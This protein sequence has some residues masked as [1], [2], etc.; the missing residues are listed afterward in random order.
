MY[1]WTKIHRIEEGSSV[2]INS[3][4]SLSRFPKKLLYI[5]I[6]QLSETPQEFPLGK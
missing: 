4:A 3:E 5:G 1:L 6:G 2:N